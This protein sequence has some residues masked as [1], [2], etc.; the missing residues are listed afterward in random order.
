MIKIYMFKCLKCIL[1]IIKRK[2]RK[3]EEPIKDKEEKKKYEIINGVKFEEIM[4]H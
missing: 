3:E 2:K 4:L 1:N